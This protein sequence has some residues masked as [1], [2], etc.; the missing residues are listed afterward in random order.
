MHLA[1]TVRRPKKDAMA[2]A[3]PYPVSTLTADCEAQTRRPKHHISHWDLIFRP[4]GVDES[5]VN[6]NYAGHGTPESPFVVDFLPDD[7]RNPLMFPK[8]KKWTITMLVSMA[9]FTIAIASS[10]YSGGITEIMKDFDVGTEV[11]LLG[12]SLF[13]LGFAIGPL[14]W[15]PLSGALTPSLTLS[16]KKIT[17]T[18]SNAEFMGRQVLFFATFIALTAFNGAAAGA[19]NIQALLIFRFLAGSFGSSP[20]TNSGGVIA[21]LF[22]AS[23]RGLALAIFAATVFLGPSLGPI[24]GGF[25]AEAAGWRWLEGLITIMTGLV[26]ILCSLAVP[27]TYAPVLLRKR[28]AT[29]SRVTGRVFVS[30]LD[31]GQ[32]KTISDQFR[33]ALLRPWVLLFRE[34][35]VLLL[36]IY[37]AIIYAILY[38]LFAAFPIVFTAGRGWSVAIGNLPFLGVTVGMMIG[39]VYSLW[40]NQRYA[41]LV[42]RNGGH[43]APEARLP[44]SILA[45]VLLPVGLFAFAWTNG[46]EIHWIVP[47]IA[48]GFFGAGLILVFL[49]SINYLIDSY[50]IYA[51]SVLAASAVTRSLLGCAL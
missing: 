8:W 41:A 15:G 24:A 21:D 23:E 1:L 37:M 34:P 7:A 45:S 48:S 35:I 28:A 18:Q 20:L 43:A 14:L 19:P 2:A 40:D 50:V 10:A 5:V 17:L 38:S 6:H 42:Q 12:I 25:L 47:T 49:S 46:P 36:S 11:T 26:W 29:L 33:V 16:L 9:T 30:K 32:K 3:T 4:G 44:P 13:V 27:E 51:A 39:I 22:S 31:M